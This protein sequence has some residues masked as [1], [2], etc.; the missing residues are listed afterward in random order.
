MNANAKAMADA[1]IAKDAVHDPSVE[2]ILPLNIRMTQ[3]IAAADPTLIKEKVAGS[4][5]SWTRANRHKTAFAANAIMPTM[6]SAIVRSDGRW[7]AEVD[8]IGR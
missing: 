2:P 8:R 6:V 4:I 1:N 5:A 3:S 7:F